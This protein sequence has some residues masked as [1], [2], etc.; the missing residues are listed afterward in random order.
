MLP[1]C[2]VL[3]GDISVELDIERSFKRRTMSIKNVVA[4][5]A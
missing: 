3:D 1:D 4:T 2:H 5:A